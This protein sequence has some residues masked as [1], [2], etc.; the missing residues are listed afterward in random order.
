MLR[1]RLDMGEFFIA[2]TMAECFSVFYA[3]FC[4]NAIIKNCADKLILGDYFE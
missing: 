1:N 2:L 3:S 4:L